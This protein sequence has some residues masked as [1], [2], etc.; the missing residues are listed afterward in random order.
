MSDVIPIEG[1][2]KRTGVDA[3]D[4]LILKIGHLKAIA[5]LVAAANSDAI[6]VDGLNVVGY[7]MGYMIDD[8]GDLSRELYHLGGAS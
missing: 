5:D 2:I 1:K 7:A 8:I 6:E 3:Y 4:D